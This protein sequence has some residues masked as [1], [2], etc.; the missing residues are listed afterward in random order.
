MFI[1]RKTGLVLLAK[2]PAQLKLK[3]NLIGCTNLKSNFTKKGKPCN[4]FATLRLFV[5]TM[6]IYK[7]VATGNGKK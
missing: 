1:S 2:T 5:E 4:K 3:L 6:P 7:A